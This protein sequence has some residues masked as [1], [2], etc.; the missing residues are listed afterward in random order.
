MRALTLIPKEV[1]KTYHV[2]KRKD[3]LEVHLPVYV[4]I[5]FDER[6]EITKHNTEIKIRNDKCVVCL[7]L[8]K[9]YIHITI[10]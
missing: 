5:D 1:K 2:R 7:Y 8:Y 3:C 10:F 6:F 9:T 4:H